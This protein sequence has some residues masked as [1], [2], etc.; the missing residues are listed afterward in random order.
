M[1][2]KKVREDVNLKHQELHDDM[3]REVAVVQNDYATL[4]K[5]ADIICDIV[6]K[7]VTLYESLSPQITQLYTTDNQ[8]FGDVIL[9]L[10]DLK[11]SVLKPATS[12]IITPEFLS[13]K[14][15]QFEAILHKQLAPLST[16]SNLLPTGARGTKESWRRFSCEGWR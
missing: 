3:L 10:K 1:D 16:I 15:T 4:Y 5:K 7:Y 13:Q 14:L 8:Q 2:V 6:M 11:E 9:M 12:S